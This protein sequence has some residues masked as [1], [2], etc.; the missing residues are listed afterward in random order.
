MYINGA[1][2]CISN[3]TGVLN[4]CDNLQGVHFKS[5]TDVMK[6]QKLNGLIMTNTS[7]G[8]SK[9]YVGDDVITSID[10]T[11][12]NSYD[13]IFFMGYLWLTSLKTGDV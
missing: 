4:K 10:L 13:K 9:I 5:I 12:I 11:G 7:W 6:S 8:S 3:A 1:L 2:S